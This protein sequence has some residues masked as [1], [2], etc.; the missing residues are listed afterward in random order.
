MS[1]KRVWWPVEILA[2]SQVYKILYLEMPAQKNFN[3]AYWFIQ[4]CGYE[5]KISDPVSDPNPAWS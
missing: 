3:D 4:C 2:Q 1:I 5:T